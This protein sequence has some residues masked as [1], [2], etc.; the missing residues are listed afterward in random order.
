MT[1]ARVVTPEFAKRDVAEASLRPLN[2]AEFVG[3][4][5]LRHDQRASYRDPGFH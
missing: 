1:E 4:R 2:L 5:Q 3:Q